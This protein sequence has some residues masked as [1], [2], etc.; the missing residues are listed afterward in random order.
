MYDLAILGAGAAG[1]SCAKSAISSNLKIAL[2]EKDINSFGGTCL[3]KGCIPTKFFLNNSK[4]RIPWQDSFQEKEAIIEKIK[5]PLSLFLKKQ[6]ID[7]IWGESSLIDTNRINI[8]GKII[9]AKNIVIA[10]GSLPRTILE[11]PN[12]IFAEELF[13]RSYLPDKILI[14]GAGYIGIEIA[15]L[16]RILGKDICVVEKEKNILPAFNDYL[17]RRLRTILEKKGIKIETE[18]DVSE[19]NLDNYDL[20]ISAVGRTP[21]TEPLKPQNAGIRLSETGYIK[22]DKYMRTNIENIYACGDIN[23][24]KLLA[25]IAEY[26]ARVCVNNIMKGAPKI[27]EDYNG[28][29]ECVFSIPQVAKVGVLEDEAKRLNIQHK[30]IKS[31]F[32]KFSSAYVYNDTDGFIEIIVDKSDKIIGAGIISQM[33][34]ELISIFSLCVKNNLPLNNLKKCLLIHPTLSEIIPLLLK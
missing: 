24:K 28:V 12:L 18:K 29:P 22:A 20:I 17:S 31:S 7:I 32:L 19:H 15:C 26:Q 3:N 9:E 21:N 2:I 25:Y 10:S 34:G 1:I 4:S 13:S 23:G 6:G 16:L 11:H 33:A 14:I 5:S 30:V 27:E 8:S